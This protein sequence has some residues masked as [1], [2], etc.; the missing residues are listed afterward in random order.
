M[1]KHNGGDGVARQLLPVHGEYA[2]INGLLTIKSAGNGWLEADC[3]LP[4]RRA[5]LD[6]MGIV[7]KE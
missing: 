4:L 6:Q 3:L 1:S 2:K 7:A 5:R